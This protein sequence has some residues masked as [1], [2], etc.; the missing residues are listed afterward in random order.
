MT[1]NSA[2]VGQNRRDTMSYIHSTLLY[3]AAIIGTSVIPKARVTHPLSSVTPEID[4]CFTSLFHNLLK[5][6]P[7]FQSMEFSVKPEVCQCSRVMKVL[8]CPRQSNPLRF[9]GEAKHLP[10]T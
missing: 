4:L 9:T 5:D 10:V 1:Q 2:T 3:G 8:I 7:P 6:T